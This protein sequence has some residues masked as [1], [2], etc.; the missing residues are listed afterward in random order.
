[1]NSLTRTRK[2]YILGIYLFCL[3]LYLKYV[4]NYLFIIYTFVLYILLHAWTW[5][6]SL[7]RGAKLKE[8]NNQ[9]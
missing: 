4:S 7:Q 9:K 8:K 6:E 2:L 3:H 1:M 5:L